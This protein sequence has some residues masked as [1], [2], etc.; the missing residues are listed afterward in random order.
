M[1]ISEG[2][3]D[4]ESFRCKFLRFV[5]E[6]KFRQ[7]HNKEFT[8]LTKRECQILELVIQG[9]NNL[10][11]STRLSISRLTV[12]QHRK[13]FNKKLHINNIADV[14]RYAMAFNIV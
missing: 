10:E 8:S 9:F 4:I 6:E 13:N 2:R 5:E 12:E 11:I 14:Y 3:V 1:T 7:E